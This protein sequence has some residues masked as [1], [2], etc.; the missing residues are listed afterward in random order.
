[1]E[2]QPVER[3]FVRE[4][5]ANLPEAPPPLTGRRNRRGLKLAGLAGLIA[6]PAL[7]LSRTA[8]SG[9]TAGTAASL[10]SPDLETAEGLAAAVVGLIRLTMSLLQT[11]AGSLPLD[12]SAAL[13]GFGWVAGAVGL[14]MIGLAA[15]SSLLAVGAGSLVKVFR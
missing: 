3:D 15:V 8:W 7:A 6:V 4:V 11:V 13:P 5:M 14:A 10:P 1:M 2:D 12:L 9:G